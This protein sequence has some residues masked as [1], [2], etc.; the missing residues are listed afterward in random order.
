MKKERG[1]ITLFVIMGML[2]FIIALINIYVM[3]VNRK[4]SQLQ[5]LEQANGE[6]DENAEDIYQSYFGEDLVNIYNVDQLL[7]IGSNQNIQVNEEGGKIY[8]YRTNGTYV[9][10]NNL[11]FSVEDFMDK[12]PNMFVTETTTTEKEETK[13]ETASYIT[14]NF[15]YTGSVQTYKA[16]Y[17]GTYELEVWGAQGG[18]PSS[19]I[20]TKGGTGGRGGYSVGEIT[21]EQGTNLYVYVGGQGE[22]LNGTTMNGSG[23]FNGGGNAAYYAGGGGGGSDIRLKAGDYY[24]RI[25]V[26]GG[27]GGGAR[28]VYP[29]D[30]GA[31]GGTSGG[32]GEYEYQ[33]YQG[34][35]AWSSRGGGN[36]YYAESPGKA[37]YFW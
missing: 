21:L 31:G 14:T 13:T 33:G 17:T 12:Y 27:G 8:N 36:G 10:R 20:S 1:A 37:R 25:I 28:G 26:A 5:I 15:S 34:K 4:Q 16:E 23:G 29:S 2:F 32:D 22:C 35:G 9:L 30:G 6:Y 7:S 11:V 24:S 3:S 18:S 19:N